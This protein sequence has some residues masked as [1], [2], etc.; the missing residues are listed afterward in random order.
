MVLFSLGFRGL[1]RE[2]P[3]LQI[4]DAAKLQ[5]H[6][7]QQMEEYWKKHYRE[8]TRDAWPSDAAVLPAGHTAAWLAAWGGAGDGW[9]EVLEGRVEPLSPGAAVMAWR[10]RAA[11]RSTH[12]SAPYH[13]AELQK[14]GN[15]RVQQ[16]VG[17]V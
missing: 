10:V 1:G 3:F 11:H 12:V 2:H 9:G 16:A 4:T 15:Q 8:C 17:F 6:I 13:R 5:R 14:T 7:P